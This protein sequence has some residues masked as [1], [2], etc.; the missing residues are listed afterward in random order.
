MFETTTFFD[1][2]THKWGNPAMI[3]RVASRINEE[4]AKYLP[5]APSRIQV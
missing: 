4:G 3:A 1:S 2:L 5:S